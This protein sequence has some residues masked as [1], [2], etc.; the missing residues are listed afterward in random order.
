MKPTAKIMPLGES[1]NSFSKMRKLK[2]PPVTI[3]ILILF[4]VT[5]IP[6]VIGLLKQSNISSRPKAAACITNASNCKHPGTG[7]CVGIA[8]QYK[9]KPT[10]DIFYRCVGNDSWVPPLPAFSPTPI[11]RL[12]NLEMAQQ[13][14]SWFDKQKNPDGVYYAFQLID[15]DNN[16]TDRIKDNRV[17]TNVLWAKYLLWTRTK[18]TNLLT[19]IRTDLEMETNTT[20]V[21][22]YAPDFW[23]CKLLYEIYQDTAIPQ[24]YQDLKTKAKELCYRGVYFALQLP[25]KVKKADIEIDVNAELNPI[26]DIDI[27]KPFK[28]DPDLD[29]PSDDYNVNMKLERKLRKFSSY[30]SDYLAKYKFDQIPNNINIAKALFNDLVDT[31]SSLGGSNNYVKGECVLGVAALD[32]HDVTKDQKYLNFATKLFSANKYNDIPLSEKAACGVFVYNLFSTTKDQQ[33]QTTMKN[34]AT[35][36]LS[37]YDPNIGAFFQNEYPQKRYEVE[38]NTLIV[39]LLLSL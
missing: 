11:T 18:D 4:A 2:L 37:N 12:S 35:S 36:M 23:S 24:D 21:D 14:V 38:S 28:L 27:E 13:I 10:D 17:G 31:Y 1:S 19:S 32:L 7:E 39:K 33:Y 29:K 5:L 9:Y 22:V 6:I 30:V 15:P 8:Y 26:A 3:V 20:K 16:V 34:T 25:V